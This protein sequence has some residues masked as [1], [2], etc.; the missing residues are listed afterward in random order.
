MGNYFRT[1]GII[2][3]KDFKREFRTLELL[4]SMFIFGLLVILI[5]NFSFDFTKDEAIRIAP[6][7]LWVAFL[8][9]GSL[10]LNRTFSLEKEN[11]ALQGI[12][13]TPI[14]R[15]SLYLGKLLAV[16]VFMIL[17]EI[18][19]LFFFMIMFNLDIIDRLPVL[20]GIIL[21]G[22][23]GFCA[24][25]T[26]ISAV[27]SNTRMREVILPILLFPIVVPVVIS[28]VKATGIILR[29]DELEGFMNWIKLLVFFDILFT[30]VSYLLFEYV[31]TE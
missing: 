19:F 8:F 29:G 30:V 13:L 11:S 6:G 9:A 18:I 25:G 5:F 24:V 23:L 10:G 27:S 15:G 1:I 20:M 4:S 2:F 14:D 31:V 3:R 17:F 21:L 22:T 26:I 16:F 7:I 28:A 12:L